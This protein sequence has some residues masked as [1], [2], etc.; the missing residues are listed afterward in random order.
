MARWSSVDAALQWYVTWLARAQ[1][2]PA[3]LETNARW[4]GLRVQVTG[5]R[6]SSDGDL[7]D[8]ADVDRCLPTCVVAREVLLLSAAGASLRELAVWASRRR[9][10]RTTLTW[11]RD[12]L[13]VSKA[14]T[15]GAMRA[16]K[17][18]LDAVRTKLA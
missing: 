6:P 12:T 1:S 18:V 15:R 9:G 4:V 11:V 2:G 7:A 16:C 8:A 3:S 17:L 10:C 5:G 13:T 14:E